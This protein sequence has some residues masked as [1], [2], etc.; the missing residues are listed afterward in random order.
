MG[1]LLNNVFTELFSIQSSVQNVSSTQNAIHCFQKISEAIGNLG[2]NIPTVF[3]T[4][5]LAMLGI[6][7]PLTIAVLQD[8]LQK[9]GD[10]ENNYSTLDLHVILDKVFQIKRLIFFSAMVFLPFIFW[11]IQIGLVRLFEIVFAMVGIA[12]ILKII[13][14]VYNW[15]K[16]NIS[17]YRKQYLMSL[18]IGEINDLIPVWTCIWENKKMSLEEEIDFFEIFSQKIDG[19]LNQ[20]ESQN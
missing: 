3:E 8:L 11:D 9:K 15:T 16:G 13:L 12:F 1:T 20:Y 19:L 4:I 14:S 17:I 6:L 7:I 5:G 18:G 10:Q 2:G